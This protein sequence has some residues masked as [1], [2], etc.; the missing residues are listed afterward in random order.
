MKA[1]PSQQAGEAGVHLVLGQSAEPLGDAGI[2]LGELLRPLVED[3]QFP[4][5]VL[6]ELAVHVETGSRVSSHL[7][8]ADVD[9]GDELDR[10]I[11][12]ACR[13]SRPTR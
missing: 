11:E 6:E 9:L 8:G 12:R 3:L 1:L 7:A 13:P 10:D 2:F 5:V 4:V